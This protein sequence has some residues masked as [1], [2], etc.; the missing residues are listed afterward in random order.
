MYFLTGARHSQPA[1]CCATLGTLPPLDR[2]GPIGGWVSAC[3]EGR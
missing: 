1:W 3:D 2:V